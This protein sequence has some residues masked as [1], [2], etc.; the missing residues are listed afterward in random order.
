MMF[1]E[2]IRALPALERRPAMRMLFVII[3]MAAILSPATSQCRTNA[4]CPA[5]QVFVDMVFK[6]AHFDNDRASRA[7]MY[8]LAIKELTSVARHHFGPSWDPGHFERDVTAFVQHQELYRKPPLGWEPKSSMENMLLFS[9]IAR[10][11]LK[12]DLNLM[13]WCNRPPGSK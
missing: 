4:L 1:L 2:F 13:R 5:V 10:D 3:I 8:K 11:G 7:K 6:T 9:G 12:I